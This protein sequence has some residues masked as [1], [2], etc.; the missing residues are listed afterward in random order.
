MPV[1][2]F[3]ALMAQNVTHRAVASRDTYGKAVFSGSGTTYRARVVYGAK[4]TTSRASGQETIADGVVWLAG[5]PTLKLDDEITLPDSSKPPI[6]N[7]DQPTDE[8]G[9]VHH[10]KIYFGGTQSGQQT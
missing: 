3:L 9:N 2:D 10:T 8:T 5:A 7:W 1:S 6:I 4:R